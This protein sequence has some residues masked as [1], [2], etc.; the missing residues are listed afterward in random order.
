MPSGQ[1]N[2]D[3]LETRM[4]GCQAGQ[5]PLGPLQ[6]VQERGNRNMGFGD[7]ERYSGRFFSHLSHGGKASEIDLDCARCRSMATGRTEPV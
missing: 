1:A 3:I 4:P 2:E 6:L 5:A 7:R